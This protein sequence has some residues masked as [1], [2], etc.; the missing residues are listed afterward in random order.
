MRNAGSNLICGT[1]TCLHRFV[2]AD[3]HIGPNLRPSTAP[4]NRRK[5]YDEPVPRGEGG[6]EGRKRNAGR[7]LRCGTWGRLFPGF[8]IVRFYRL[9][10]Q[11]IGSGP[12]RGPYFLVAEQESKQRSRPGGGA[13]LLAPAPKSRPPPGPLSGAHFWWPVLDFGL[14]LE[15]VIPSPGEKVAR[16][17]RDGRGMRA[18]T[19]FAV[20]VRASTAS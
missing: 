7:N 8:F 18:K 14:A 2:G 13:E 16:R 1:G 20:Q 15:G 19:R 12:C 9:S 5:Q 17:S 4:R 11:G 10:L 6:P 3:D